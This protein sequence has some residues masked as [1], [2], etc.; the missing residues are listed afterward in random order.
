MVSDSVCMQRFTGVP[1][2][3]CREKGAE[4][5]PEIEGDC[6]RHLRA[7][8]SEHV[9]FSKGAL[10]TQPAPAYSPER[11]EEKKKRLLLLHVKKLVLNRR[12]VFLWTWP[13]K[14]MEG[15]RTKIMKPG[16]QGQF[17][18]KAVCQKTVKSG[19]SDKEDRPPCFSYKK[20][21]LVRY[22]PHCKYFK[23]EKMSN[24][25]GFSVRSSTR[26]SKVDQPVL[27]EKKK[28]K[29]NCP[30]TKGN[31]CHCEYS[32]SPSQDCFR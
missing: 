10:K 21:I 2:W 6:E 13:G 15:L 12:K 17:W 8:T 25:K 7:S 31:G 9:H 20:E 32:K 5:L 4:E 19:P 14:D 11:T 16:S 18:R 1:V 23:T 24:G 30:K 26:K 3:Q 29:K 22:L 27:D 28:A